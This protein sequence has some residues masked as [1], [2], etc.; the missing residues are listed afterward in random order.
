MGSQSIREYGEKCPVC[1]HVD[2]DAEWI[3]ET[4]GRVI[5][6]EY[7][8]SSCDPTRRHIFTLEK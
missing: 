8:C 3:S 4:D 7:R 5:V 6:Y 1:G 2:E